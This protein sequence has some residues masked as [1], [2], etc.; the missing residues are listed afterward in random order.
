MDKPSS[1]ARKEIAFF[2]FSD[3]QDWQK[4]SALPV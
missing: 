4:F 3:D 2:C 1:F